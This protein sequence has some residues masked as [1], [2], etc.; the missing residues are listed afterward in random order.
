MS[1][2]AFN[3]A[4]VPH[5]VMVARKARADLPSISIQGTDFEQYV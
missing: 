3:P 4:G 5:A 1:N 2:A